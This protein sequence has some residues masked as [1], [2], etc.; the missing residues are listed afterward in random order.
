MATPGARSGTLFSGTPSTVLRHVMLIVHAHAVTWI[1]I[2][3]SV[4]PDK[5]VLNVKL[6]IEY[7][8]LP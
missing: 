6:S 5:C 2:K 7:V 3:R 1:E 8:L 4:H